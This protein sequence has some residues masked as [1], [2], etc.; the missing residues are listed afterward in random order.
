M[1]QTL[2]LKRFRGKDGIVE[3]K[4]LGHQTLGVDEDESLPYG[5]HQSTVET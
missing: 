2:N 1:R 3:V 5:P 4:L